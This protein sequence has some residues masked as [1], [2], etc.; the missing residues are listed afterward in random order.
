MGG[1][2]WRRFVDRRFW[3][4]VLLCS[5]PESV[6]CMPDWVQ[7]RRRSYSLRTELLVQTTR[8]FAVTC[9]FTWLIE[10]SRLLLLISFVFFFFF[11]DQHQQN[12]RRVSIHLAF[13]VVERVQ[14]GHRT[15]WW[16]L[17]VWIQESFQNQGMFLSSIRLTNIKLLMLRLFIHHRILAIW[18]P[19]TVASWTVSTVNFWWQHLSMCTFPVSFAPLRQLNCCSR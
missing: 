14:L 11:I 1:L 10:V 8:V 13:V 17:C 4:C 19:A 9:E 16:F 18:F 15:I 3:H 2:H 7:W 6:L 5:V 12:F